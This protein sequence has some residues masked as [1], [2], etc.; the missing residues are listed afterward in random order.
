MLCVPETAKVPM[1][2]RAI[3]D[4]YICLLQPCQ[5]DPQPA[6]KCSIFCSFVGRQSE[7]EY[8]LMARVLPTLFVS[9]TDIIIVS[10]HGYIFCAVIPY[11]YMHFPFSWSIRRNITFLRRI[12]FW[13]IRE[14]QI[15][16]SFLSGSEVKLYIIIIMVSNVSFLLFETPERYCSV[17]TL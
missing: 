6:H 3:L 17:S 14:Y 9:L 13:H 7:T 15:L 11:R 1:H 8:L 16:F 5:T 12:L 4:L 2:R 10:F